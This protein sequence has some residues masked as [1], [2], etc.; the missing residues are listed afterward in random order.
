MLME[1]VWTAFLDLNG[2]RTQGFNGPNPITYQDIRA[3]IDLTETPLSAWEVEAI[4]RL[5]RLFMRVVANGKL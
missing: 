2:A 1:Y 5:D 3:W 4:K